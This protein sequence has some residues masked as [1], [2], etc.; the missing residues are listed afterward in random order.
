VP[1]LL[2]GPTVVI[3]GIP[4]D[5]SHVDGDA[6]AFPYRIFREVGAEF[7]PVNVPGNSPD[8]F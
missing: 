6:L 3:A 1:D 5:V 8:R 2:P 7:R 4:A